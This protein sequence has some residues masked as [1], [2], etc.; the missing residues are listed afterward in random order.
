[1]RW[2]CWVTLLLSA[3]ALAMAGCSKSPGPHTLVFEITGRGELSLLS[4]IIDGR[5]TTERSITVPWRKTIQ[6]PAKDGGHTWQLKTQQGS[7]SGSFQVV[8]LVD[9]RPVTNGSCAGDGC[10]SDHSGSIGD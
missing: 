6:L 9:G 5:E 7:G 3:A 4:Y 8:V 10:S 1:M 2:R